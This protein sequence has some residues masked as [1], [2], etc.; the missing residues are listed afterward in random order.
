MI[1]FS[2]AFI[3]AQTK[4]RMRKVRT[5]MTAGSASILFGLLIAAILIAAGTI[6][7]GR[8]FM[9]G[10]LSERYLV[11]YIDYNSQPYEDTPE[12]RARATQLYMTRIAEKKAEAKRLGIEFDVS[13]E[14]KPVSGD[15]NDPYIDATVPTSQLAIKEQLDQRKTPLDKLKESV[16]RY[17]PSAYYTLKPNVVPEAGRIATMEGGKEN[18]EPD[19]NAQYQMNPGIEGGW[20]YLDKS[21]TKPFLLD[22]S[23]LSA[24]TNKN[25]IPVIAPIS[26]VEKA[27]GLPKLAKNAPANERLERIK[28][29][30]AHA[31]SATFTVCYRNSL[32]VQ[33]VEEAKR[34]DKEIKKNTGNKDYQKPSL[35]YGLPDPTACVA[36]VI[37]SD[38]RSTDEKALV[39]KQQAF[40]EKFGETVH[41][42]QQKLTFRVVGLAPDGFDEQSF[43]NVG[44]LVSVVTGSS[45]QGNWVVPQDMYDALPNKVEYDKYIPKSATEAASVSMSRIPV[46]Q[47]IEF[48]SVDE[49]RTFYTK[50]N[51]SGADCFNKPIISYFGSNS[52]MLDEL[53]GQAQ[54]VLQIAG[55]VIG[56]I[57][58]LIMMGMV[59]RV[60]VD[61]RRE[62]AV[63][64]AIGASRNDLRAV[65]V[66][67]T[68]LFAL[69]VFVIAC[70]IGGGIALW[71]DNTYSQD[72][73]VHAHLAFLNAPEDAKFQLIGLWWQAVAAV[74]GL[75]LI[76]SLVSIL[77]PLA[78][79]L[80]RNPIKDM[81]DE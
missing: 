2:D 42:M 79:N 54:K 25:D 36:P 16:G 69:I 24:Q 60:I 56:S 48:A 45:L 5:V 9:S 32:S 18:F 41:P 64:R 34:I 4:L 70:L 63:F 76:A 73:T 20:Y 22:Q 13:S 77:L 35:I 37:K 75:I 47:L 30:R 3:L 78:R 15:K 51:C 38:I 40:N 80:A 58:A 68:T 8:Q 57:A 17:H 6:T 53:K 39:A 28:Y 55:L 31:A 29:I 50:E 49:V 65:Y 66:I 52:V 72:A 23:A 11:S 27:L 81:R 46:G 33:Q 44:A 61:S 12:L 74:G 26:K 19:V 10:G 71:V 14:P 59:G 1:R 7:S 43:S 62:T 21:V 67:Y